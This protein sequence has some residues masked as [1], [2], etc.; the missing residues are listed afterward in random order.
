LE[1]FKKISLVERILLDTQRLSIYFFHKETLYPT[2]PINKIHWHKRKTPK[3][4]APHDGENLVKL[5][6]KAD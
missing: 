3:V 2:Y 4:S 5:I 1:T 6:G